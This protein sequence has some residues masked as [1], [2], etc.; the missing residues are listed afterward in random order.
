MG[1]VQDCAFFGGFWGGGHKGSIKWVRIL[2]FGGAE[3][4]EAGRLAERTQF[5]NV[6]VEGILRNEP[7]FGNAARGGSLSHMTKCS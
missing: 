5:G 2:V 3:M 6:V 1:F 7:N 4:A